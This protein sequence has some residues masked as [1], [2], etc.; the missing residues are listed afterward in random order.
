[1]ALL[2]V[3]IFGTGRGG[4]YYSLFNNNE[5]CEVVAVCDKSLN[6]T[7]NDAD[8]RFGDTAKFTEF[9]EFL[10]Y[11][12]KNGMNL[13]FLANFFHQHAPYAVKAMEAGMDV[14]SECTAAGTLKECVDLVEAVER[15][16]RKYILA[17]NYPFMTANLKMN[18]I[19]KS[20]KLGTLLY[21]EG[22]Y[23]HSGSN[24]DLARL[25]PGKY[26]WRAWMPRTYYLTHAFG[27]LMFMSDSMPRY[28]S[29]RSVHS[30]LL[31][32]NTARKNCDGTAILFCEM[33]NGM[34]ARFTGCTGMASDYSR[35]RVVGDIASVES[36]GNIGP[37]EVRLYYFEH[38]KPADEKENCRVIKADLSDFGEKGKRAAAAGH[39]G[40]DFWIVENTVDCILNDKEPFFDVYRAAAMSATAI[41]GW[42]SCLDH[43]ENFRI[44]DFRNKEDRDSVRNDCSTPFPDENGNGATMPCAMPY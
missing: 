29:A 22:E 15:T 18:E 13:V 36:G 42:K 4:D 5:N 3:G 27:P 11:G 19:V 38:T 41:L 21:A 34:I 10:E 2:K 1:M 20:G 31:E 37:D 43:G 39:G 23:N 33:D 24:E 8:G 12:R 14:L 9:D 28:V 17:E 6:V 40:G 16:G 44:P 25:T 30:K 35:Y 7:E 32:K 26:H